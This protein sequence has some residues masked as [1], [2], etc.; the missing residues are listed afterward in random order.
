MGIVARVSRLCQSRCR[1]PRRNA[2][3]HHVARSSH[4]RCKPR[5]SSGFRRLSQ[6][7]S[8][9]TNAERIRSHACRTSAWSTCGLFQSLALQKKG[10]S[11]SQDFAT[12]L[13][14]PQHKQNQRHGLRPVGIRSFDVREETYTTT[15]CFDPLV[16]HR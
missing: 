7:V 6:C 8:S 11:R 5:K 4:H 12:G 3:V 1:L 13:G 15:I 10:S 14:Y 16:S 2:K 9:I